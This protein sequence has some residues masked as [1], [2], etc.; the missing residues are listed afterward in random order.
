MGGG[1]QRPTALQEFPPL[2]AF[3]A[4]W[5]C[6]P[7]EGKGWVAAGSDGRR[8]RPVRRRPPFFPAACAAPFREARQSRAESPC[9]CAAP[10]R[11]AHQR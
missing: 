11:E 9:A 1:G 5:W 4:E 6:L 8:A 2:T 3:V 10:F 7:G